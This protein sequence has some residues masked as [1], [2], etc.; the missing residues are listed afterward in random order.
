[1]EC[2]LR[3]ALDMATRSAL[4]CLAFAS[5]A[6]LSS[7]VAAACSAGSDPSGFDEEPGDDGAGGEAPAGATASSADGVG[8]GFDPSGGTG[9]GSCTSS[10]ELDTDGDG[11]RGT[12]GDCNDCDPNVNPAAI[13]VVVTEPGEDGEVPAPAD[14]DC[15]GTID[16]LIEPCD[17]GLALD[18]P[19]ALHG[20]AAIEL[21]RKADDGMWGVA[22]AAYVRADGSPATS[23]LQV[24][25]MP[26]FGN[27]VLTQRGESMLV[28]SSGHARVPGQ[29]GACKENSC[30]GFGAGTP[31]PGFPQDVPGCAGDTAINDDVGLEVKMI[32]PSNATGYSF[33]F[34]FY[35]FEYPEW[36]CTDFNDQFIALVSPPPMGSVNGNISFD[37]MSNPVSVNIAFFQVCAGCALGEAELGGTGF[38]GG[39]GDDA[40][41]TSWLK[42]T[43]PVEGGQEL[44]IRF[45]IWDTGD[46]AWDSTVLVDNF[47][48]IATGGT[49]TVDTT[50]VPK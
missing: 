42:T 24:G 40:G 26:T 28:L 47:Q 9:G 20:A 25:V 6:S 13:E 43:A 30:S 4:R 16:E 33:D 37:S 21:C 18:D 5:L 10:P 1:M 39:W 12:D 31:P 27:S 14:E 50:P 29:T 35:S 45:A 23:S 48:W 36:V 46:D 11:F 17:A 49:V 38:G 34:D 8:G 32:A 44:T 19:D 3:R 7:L 15:N 41:A 2:G 22:S